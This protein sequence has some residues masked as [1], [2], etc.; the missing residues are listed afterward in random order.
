MKY[1][2]FHGGNQEERLQ[3]FI[4]SHWT[5]IDVKCGK[6]VGFYC[7]IERLWQNRHTE[8]NNVMIELF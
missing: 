6:F 5:D 3:A 8:Q 1:V 4:K 2:E 7:Q